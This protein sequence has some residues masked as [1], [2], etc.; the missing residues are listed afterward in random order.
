MPL[1]PGLVLNPSTGVISGIPTAD[2][3]FPF[4]ATVTDSIGA[5][6][7]AVLGIT[8]AP[9]A[10]QLDSLIIADQ[11]ELMGGPNG[12]PSTN[13]RCA[14]AVFLVQPGYDLGA[15]QP[16]S[17]F[18][19]SLILDGERPFGYRASDRTITLP[20]IVWAPT[21]G[22]L[23]GAYEVLMAAIDEQT[24]TLTWTRRGGL[25]LI[26]DCFRAQPTVV[27]WGG[28]DQ[29]LGSPVGSIALTFQALPYG[30]SDT[31][32][33]I[34]VASPLPGHDP[35]ATPALLDDFS[36]IAGADNFLSGPN[37]GFEGGAGTWHSGTNATIALSTAAAHSGLSSLAV[38]S[39]AAGN[40]NATSCNAPGI[41]ANGMP[42]TPGSTVT[43]GTWFLAATTARSVKAG[44]DWYDGT[45]TYLSTSRSAAGPDS[46]TAWALGTALLLTPA[47]AA[48]CRSSPQVIAAGAGGET[49]YIDDAFLAVTQWQPSGRC[50]VGPNSANWDPCNPPVSDCTGAG[51]Q[52]GAYYAAPVSP[53][54]DITG[55]PALSV[56]AGFGSDYYSTW[57]KGPAEFDF[58]LTDVSG[59]TISFS[60]TMTVHA[61]DD[62]GAP[63][64]QRVTA[65]IPQ[66]RP[67]FDYTTVSSYSINVTNRGYHTLRYAQLYLDRLVAN[68]HSVQN[69]PAV[70]GAMYS[71]LGVQGTARTTCSAEFQQ[72]PG[73]AP[74]VTVLLPGP[75]GTPQTWTCPPGVTSVKVE[76][77]G[78]GGGGYLNGGGGGEYAAEAAVLVTPQAQYSYVIGAGTAMPI[79]GVAAAP[80]GPTTFTGDA[81]TV[82]ANGGAPG[83]RSG[84]GGAGGSGSTSTT[85]FS[86][87]SGA[88]G[89]SG[90]LGGGGGGSAGSGGAGG[91]ASG[92]AAGAAGAGT[93]PGAAGGGGTT[94]DRDGFP[95]KAPGGGGGGVEDLGDNQGGAGAPGQIQL[96]Y[97][98][99]VAP[100]STLIAHRPGPGAPPDLSPLVSFGLG[101]VPD[102]TTEYPVQSLTPGVYA[103]FGG[104]YSVVAVAG[105]WN[106][107]TAARTV[108]VTVRQ[109]EAQG[110]TSYSSSVS[111]TF[112]PSTDTFL[113]G[114]ATLAQV[115]IV[116]LGELTL[117]LQDIA[118]DNTSALFTITITDSNTADTWLDCCFLDTTG[119]TVAIGIPTAQAYVSL[120]TDEPDT[121]VAL[122]RVLGSSFGRASAVSVMQNTLMSGGP[123]FLEPGDN[124][125][126]IYAR[127]GSP[128]LSVSY[129]P[130]WRLER[131]Y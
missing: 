87:G 71:I 86:G 40:F 35:P 107:P 28:T 83:A 1:P 60:R 49:H 96:T 114:G 30:R 27:T 50:V 22:I 108:K 62:S 19:A 110:G 109:Y 116:T 24:W 16:T 91:N 84:A 29:R 117:P 118:P 93:T 103:T 126:L 44:V 14:G 129:S 59:N 102:G 98:S 41:L 11:I 20:I 94:A 66:N 53:S 79:P 92:T 37:A 58:T 48:V 123:L 67:G 75:V 51:S 88:A 2:G 111:R 80:T 57:H 36:S 68:P 5:T 32:T 12:V 69:P 13:P 97:T 42:V 77:T 6:V 31:P 113:P 95:G 52:P 43:V 7:S 61:S 131:L 25:P 26:L 72:P 112:T 65:H 45:G 47:G 105:T 130:R 124:L 90:T 10:V 23:A 21:F 73:S 104:T 8:V 119:Q 55:L 101:D 122:G 127:E 128:A 54:V 70:R 3:T 115:P 9:A 121:S 4:T 18:V 39:V 120:Y 17:D 85:H 63:R 46:T 100:F 74:Q 33:E 89:T 34:L 64:W 76:C 78:P 106:A 99:S 15:P 38:T 125:L 81:V 82:T 56:W